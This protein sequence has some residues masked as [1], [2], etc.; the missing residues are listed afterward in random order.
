LSI[1]YPQGVDSNKDGLSWLINKFDHRKLYYYDYE[2]PPKPARKR[3]SSVLFFGTKDNKTI[4]RV[5]A[6]MDIDDEV[7]LKS[8]P[9]KKVTFKWEH[10]SHLKGHFY[11]TS[12]LKGHFS[13]RVPV[14][15]TFRL[16]RTPETRVSAF[17]AHLQV[18]FWCLQIGFA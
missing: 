8:K 18:I 1:K 10:R 5:L 6:S 11:R 12:I 7:I 17:G 14:K 13:N 15:V 2:G 9:N 16:F 4:P 3:K